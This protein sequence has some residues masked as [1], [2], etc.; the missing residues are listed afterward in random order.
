M[1]SKKALLLCIMT[2]AASAC[3]SD[4]VSLQFSQLGLQGRLERGATVDVVASRGTAGLVVEPGSIVVTPA[5]AA[6]VLP[7]GQLRLD[8]AG[9]ITVQARANNMTLLVTAH[10]ATPPTVW[11]HMFVSG[12]RDIYSVAL[13]G[14]DLARITTDPADDHDPS[15]SAQRLVFVSERTG[16]GDLYGATLTG[17]ALTRLTQTSGADAAPALSADGSKLVFMRGPVGGSARLWTANADGS[18]AAAAPTGSFAGAIEADPTWCSNSRVLFMS[19]D[20]GGADLFLLENNV[21]SAFLAT[22][23]PEVEPSCNAD[24]SRAVFT[25]AGEDNRSH[26][27]L[28]DVST[29]AVTQLTNGAESEGSPAFLAD[30]RVV[31]VRFTPA[32][33]TLMWV[34]PS[35]PETLH[36]IPLPAG[37][38]GAPTAI[39]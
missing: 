14:L 28:L 16:G 18:A 27:A 13:D 33:G 37:T 9:D 24:G 10:V 22:E 19:T 30:G 6:T 26:I 1:N 38:A 36:T 32:G 5:G 3:S 11:F 25:F 12:N 29:R 7:S 23:A 20:N 35:A 17:A 8:S 2:A 15:V 34:D 21:V 39:R 31:F 4:S